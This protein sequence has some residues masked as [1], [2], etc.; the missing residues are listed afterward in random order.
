MQEKEDAAEETPRMLSCPNQEVI[1][2]QQ[3]VPQRE[4]PK[5]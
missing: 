5:R 1:M 4:K 2:P 3:E